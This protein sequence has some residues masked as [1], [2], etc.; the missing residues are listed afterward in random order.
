MNTYEYM[1]IYT[2]TH[3]MYSLFD[4][5]DF[6]PFSN[7][8]VFSVEFKV[9]TPGCAY[10]QIQIKSNVTH[11]VLPPPVGHMVCPSDHVTYESSHVTYEKTMS[12][13]NESCHIYICMS[14]VTHQE[15]PPS[16]LPMS[17]IN[18]VTSH[19]N[20]SSHTSMSHVAFT[21]E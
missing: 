13:V 21:Y 20:K 19:T 1:Y 14:H 7:I 15:T 5:F 16:A 17:H 9:Q 12:H 10:I 18:R 2:R 11:Q 6:V 8:F 3:L 4:Y